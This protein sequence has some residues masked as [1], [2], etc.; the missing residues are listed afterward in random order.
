MKKQRHAPDLFSDRTHSQIVIHGPCKT[1][2]DCA[3]LCEWYQE[4]FAH[5]PRCFDFFV[6]VKK[7]DGIPI[8]DW[9]E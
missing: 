9:E 1:A 8:Q 2:D 5:R 7:C 4:R 3:K 6:C